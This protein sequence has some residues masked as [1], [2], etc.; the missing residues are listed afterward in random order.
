MSRKQIII[1]S[2]I[3]FCINTSVNGAERY[4]YILNDPCISEFYLEATKAIK[5]PE[6]HIFKEA[7][8]LI[9]RFKIENPLEEFYNLSSETINFLEE[10]EYFLAK[11]KKSAIIEV[12]TEVFALESRRGIKNWELSTII[13][14]NIERY[15]IQKSSTI[16]KENIKSI[17]YG[18]FLPVKNTSN[19]GGKY[20]SRVDIIIPCSIS[21]E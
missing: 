11:I 20:S 3:F 9:I 4:Q 16:T 17:G 12:H 2:I 5:D 19:N 21:G 18:E 13:A 8:G 10:I 6:I 15:L 14:N 1:L 7:F